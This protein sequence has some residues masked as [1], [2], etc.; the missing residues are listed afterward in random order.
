MESLPCGEGNTNGA[1][2]YHTEAT[3]STGLPCPS[4]NNNQE[5]NCVVFPKLYDKKLP[6]GKSF[7]VFGYTWHFMS[8]FN[9]VICI[10]CYRKLLTLSIQYILIHTLIL[11]LLLLKETLRYSFS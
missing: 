11:N 3:C 7:V 1:L 4:Y 9:T 10:C 5:L 6:E 2:F 8:L